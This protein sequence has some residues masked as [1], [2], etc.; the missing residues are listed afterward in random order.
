MFP[1]KKKKK[2]NVDG[3]SYEMSETGDDIE[4]VLLIRVYIRHART[5]YMF[6]VND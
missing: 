5:L 3:D 1:T 4:I 6:F 2:K